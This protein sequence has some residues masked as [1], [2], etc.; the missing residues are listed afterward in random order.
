MRNIVKYHY[1]PR[2]GKREVG[3]IME[4]FTLAEALQTIEAVRLGYKN[5]YTV[6]FSQVCATSMRTGKIDDLK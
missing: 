4:P 6:R 5:Y 3:S 2:L 1:L